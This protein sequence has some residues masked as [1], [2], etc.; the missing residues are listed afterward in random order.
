MRKLKWI[1]FDFGGCLDSD[2]MHSRALFF[3]QFLKYNLL[4]PG[5][6]STTFNEAYT[7]SDRLVVAN[8]LII[9]STLFEMNA[10][11]CFHIASKLKIS[12]ASMVTNIAESITYIQSKY[13]KRNRKIL[14][15]LAEQYQLGIVSNFS[16][17]LT[18]IL[19]EFFMMPYFNFV[20]DSYHVGFSKPNSAIFNLALQKCKA[21]PNEICFIG[22]NIANDI[23]PAKALGMKTVLICDKGGN[24][25]ADYTLTS[26]EEFLELTHKT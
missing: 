23:R 21:A 3:N 1:L 6:S 19:N 4:I 26:L 15:K 18:A 7:Y 20:L 9:N 12:N 5:E 8:S 11:M 16:G 14:Q 24:S 10:I 13:L 25:E 17:N 2:G 22:D